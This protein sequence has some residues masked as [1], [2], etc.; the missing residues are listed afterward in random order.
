M[1]HSQTDHEVQVLAIMMFISKDVLDAHA[2]T[3]DIIAAT[4][5]MVDNAQSNTDNKCKKNI[6]EPK[7]LRRW[8]RGHQVIVRAGGHIESWQ[9]LYKQVDMTL[10]LSYNVIANSFTFFPGQNHQA[11]SSSLFYNGY[12]LSRHQGV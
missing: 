10:L 1:S 12:K 11:R 8:S 9:P 3:G 6:G 5:S 4:S 2:G 7:R